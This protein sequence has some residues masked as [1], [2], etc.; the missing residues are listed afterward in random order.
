M[1][2]ILEG[3][4]CLLSAFTVHCLAVSVTVIVITIQARGLQQQTNKQKEYKGWYQAV[5]GVGG[6]VG[7]CEISGNNF[8][9]TKQL[10]GNL[11]QRDTNGG[12]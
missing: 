1:P 11:W 4:L 3:C 12:I 2:I 6:V 7:L 5:G 8:T 10:E 9:S